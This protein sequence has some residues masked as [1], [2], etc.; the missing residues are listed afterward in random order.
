MG[1]DGSELIPDYEY[2]YV[3]EVRAREAFGNVLERLG[4]GPASY[5]NEKTIT[6]TH[7]GL[8]DMQELK[9][10]GIVSSYEISKVRRL[11]QV[12]SRG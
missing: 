11:R 4:I 7:Q 12:V 1:P 8:I 10:R 5:G 9:D 6:F 2:E 3:V